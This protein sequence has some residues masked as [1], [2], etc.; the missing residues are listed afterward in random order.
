[1]SPTSSRRRLAGVA[2]LA[3][4]AVAFVT[5]APPAGAAEF[6]VANTNDAGAGSLRDAVAAAAANPGDD[7]VVI[8]AGM[9]PFNLLSTVD[10]GAGNGL[11][12]VMGNGNEVIVPGN[13]TV[14]SSSTSSMV[15]DDLVLRSRNGAN[16]AS[17]S[18]TV[19]N[20]VIFSND[21]DGVNTA[22]GPMVVEDT[23][24]RG[25]NGGRGI[26]SASGTVLAQRVTIVAENEGINTSSGNIRVIGSQIVP[27]GDS[28]GIGIDSGEGSII[29][30]DSTITGWPVIGIATTGSVTVTN[31]TVADNPGHGI[32]ATDVVLVYA[33]V[34]GNGAPGAF[35]NLDA[36]NVETFASVIGGGGD[37]CFVGTIVSNGYNFVT[38]DTC[39]LTGTADENDGGDPGLGPLVP[40]GGLTDTLLPASTSPLVDHVPLAE[41][42]AD[43]ATG[44]TT[45][46]RGLSRPSG[47]G[48]D[49]GAVE[50]QVEE[51]GGPTTAA[52]GGAVAPRFTG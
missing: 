49:V 15:L 8:P 38:D 12:T 37:A 23:V 44:L 35:N 16:S 40:N 26:N 30:V 4:A 51:P 6:V 27:E 10:Y 41:C 1:M 2:V 25:E 32:E 18:L 19:R 22:S 36:A 31:S 33:T 11:L 50:V 5:S 48:C 14:F 3:L 28:A 20:S 45:D 9:G 7:V 29:V 43:G 47:Q 34:V 21:G 46:Q 42:Q 52:P 24:I 17:G 39:G 13:F